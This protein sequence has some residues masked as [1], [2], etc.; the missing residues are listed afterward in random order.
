M[1]S[2]VGIDVSKAK[3]DVAV[4]GHGVI[5]AFE[6]TAEGLSELVE[7]LEGF[8]VQCIVLEA[9][10]GYEQ[11]VL[12][13]LWTADLPCVLVSPSRARHFARALSQYAKTDE[14][15]AQVLAHMAEVAVGTSPLWCPPE[16][17]V[18]ELRGLVDRR[19]QLIEMVGAEVKRLRHVHPK[20][21]PS[22]ERIR[23][24]L[25][26]ELKR[27]DKAIA[28]LIA[29]RNSLRERA[30]VIR[31]VSGAGPQMA[32]TLLSHLPELGRLTRGSVAALAGL[33]P[34][35]RDSGT[36]RGQRY[37]RGGRKAVRNVLYMAA[38]SATRWNE[39]LKSFYAGLLARGKPPKVA[40]IAVARKLLVHL[41]SLMRAHLSQPTWAAA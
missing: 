18:A 2:G 41:N 35:N 9:S 29:G 33:A 34:M 17:E 16:P 20:L 15:D 7:T 4:R 14:L 13:A 22:I 1:A 11:A 23:K 39:H 30:A 32:A 6:R 8:D 12:A 36:K 24:V 27:V 25:R 19:N 28:A 26:A 40:L 10:G 38:L 3:V 31:S 21:R 5:G 37:I